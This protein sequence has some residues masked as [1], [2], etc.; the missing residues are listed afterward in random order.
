MVSCDTNVIINDIK[1]VYTE[2]ICKNVKRSNMKGVQK[3]FIL[4]MKVN[5][6]RR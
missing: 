3:K 1:I 4:N 5:M 2:T 6:L